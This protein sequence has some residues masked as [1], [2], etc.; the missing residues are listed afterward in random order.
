VPEDAL[1]ELPEVGHRTGQDY[2][3]LA[4]GQSGVVQSMTPAGKDGAVKLTFVPQPYQFTVQSCRETNK[5]DGITKE[6]KLI[7]R[8]VCRP[9]AT[10]RPSPPPYPRRAGPA[11][12]R[13]ARSG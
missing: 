3:E 9:G 11:S 5:V 7:C 13:G 8:E 10:A 4:R 2:S 12:R 6:G 1:R